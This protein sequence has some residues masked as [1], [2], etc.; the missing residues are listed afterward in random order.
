MVDPT[1]T[2]IILVQEPYIYPNMC[3][4]IA[5]PK[6]CTYYPIQ[7]PANTSPHS[8]ILISM[9]ID[10]NSVAQIP[11]PSSH[12]TAITISSTS[13]VLHIYNIYNPPNS[14]LALTNLNN[15]LSTAV[16]TQI[17]T[18]DLGLWPTSLPHL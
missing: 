1:N 18:T 6:W 4:S 9:L 14:D 7:P 3:Q 16:M 17:M 11:I 15:W 2:D 13:D 8:F 10:P 5:S 12:V